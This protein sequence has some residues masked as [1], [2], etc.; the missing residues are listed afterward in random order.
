MLGTMS[1]PK[2]LS[3]SQIPEP[4]VNSLLDNGNSLA[5]DFLAH[6]GMISTVLGEYM[7]EES[8]GASIGEKQEKSALVGWGGMMEQVMLFCSLLGY[9]Y[10]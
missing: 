9:Y 4:N 3:S 7:R 2:L 1:H 5:D 6:E 10:Y 8:N